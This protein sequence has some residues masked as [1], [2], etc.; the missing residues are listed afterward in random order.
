MFFPRMPSVS[1]REMSSGGWIGNGCF[2]L[3]Q[4]KPGQGRGGQ[5]LG[6][7]YLSPSLVPAHT[8]C[9][10]A[11]ISLASYILL[12]SQIPISGAGTS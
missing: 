9:Q 1:S 4:D 5:V 3:C 8:K 10:S 2:W 7:I 11:R 12:G 6:Y